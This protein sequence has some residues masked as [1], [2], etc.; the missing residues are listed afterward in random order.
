[1]TTLNEEY[2]VA[3]S[4]ALYIDCLIVPTFH[5]DVSGNLRHFADTSCCFLLPSLHE[6]MMKF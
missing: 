1:M 2:A 6:E 5:D 3:G 4:K